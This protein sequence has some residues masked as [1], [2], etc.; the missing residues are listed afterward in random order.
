MEIH[1]LLQIR[2]HRVKDK[3]RN[4]LIRIRFAD[5]NDALNITTDSEA[6]S[7]MLSHQACLGFLELSKLME[8]V[9]D[10]DYAAY[11]KEQYE[12]LKAA[13]NEKAW[14]GSWY[15]RALTKDGRIGS[16]DSEGSKIY[17]NAQT[18]G[19]LG[20]VVPEER[21]KQ[22]QAAIDSMEQDFGFPLNLPPYDH[23]QPETG[24]MS[25][26]LPGLFE[27]GG[28]YC[29][30][31]AFK[32]LADC[33]L[34]RAQEAVRTLK[35]IMPDSEKNPSGKS[36][37]EPYVFTNC[38][39]TYPKYYGKSYQSWTTGTLAWALR[40][41]AEGILGVQRDYAGLLLVPCMPEE[42]DSAEITRYFRRAWHHIVICNPDHRDCGTPVIAVDSMQ[43]NGKRIPDFHDRKTHEVSVILR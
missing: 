29:R 14:D 18:W 21:M 40:C 26:M 39:A 22:V 2:K 25:G 35:K 20:N 24:R 10:T 38:Y 6:E 16:R 34:G 11:L 4:G 1:A 32:L 3:G 41:M 43:L 13:I 19:I 12:I 36:G 5:W 7:V 42:W 8:T 31:S 27:N 33:K 28:V 15:V 30:A 9:G 23:Y 37:A 17:L